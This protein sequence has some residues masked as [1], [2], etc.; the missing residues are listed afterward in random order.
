MDTLTTIINL[1][2]DARGSLF[3]HLLTLLVLQAALV[4]AL[5]HW[6]RGANDPATRRLALAAAGILATRLLMIVLGLFGL[7]GMPAPQAFS[8]TA[9][10]APLERA[11]DTIATLLLLWALLTPRERWGTADLLLGIALGFTLVAAI[12][13]ISSWYPQALAG[14]HYNNSNGDA[15]WAWAQLLLLLAGLVFEVGRVTLRRSG[16]PVQPGADWS[17][18]SLVYALLATGNVLQLLLPTLDPLNPMVIASDLPGPVRVAQVLAWPL[19]AAYVWRHVLSQTRLITSRDRTPATWPAEILS[20]S[21]IIGSSL[22]EHRTIDQIAVAVATALQADVAAVAVPSPDEAGE[23]SLSAVYDR[24]AQ[25]YLS[26]RSFPLDEVTPLRSAIHRRRPLLLEPGHDDRALSRLLEYMSS[27][28]TGLLLIQPMIYGENALGAILVGNP[29]TNRPLTDEDRAIASALAD[30]AALALTLA[31]QHEDVAARAEQLGQIAREREVT[32][33]PLAQQLKDAQAESRHF[34][35]RLTEMQAE[36]DHERENARHLAQVVA[37]DG[38]APAA[39]VR[40]A[41]DLEDAMRAVGERDSEIARLL[42]AIAEQAEKMSALDKELGDV[43]DVARTLA[44]E[45]DDAQAQIA[46]LKDPAEF[47]HLNDQLARTQLELVEARNAIDDLAREQLQL[48]GTQRLPAQ[49]PNTTYQPDTEVLNAVVQ[50]LRTP[51]T[52]LLGYTD[53]LLDESVGILGAMQRKF[54]QRIKTNVERMRGIMDDL[55]RLTAIET[56]QLHLE[57]QPVDL[58]EVIAEAVSR[59]SGQFR[60]KGITLKVALAPGLPAIKADRD[61][62][63]QVFVQLLHNAAL[64]S[65][66]DGEVV[67]EMRREATPGDGPDAQA[68]D[69]SDAGAGGNHIL[70]ALRDSG[71]GIAPEDRPRVFNRIYRAD[72]PLIPGVGDTGVGLSIAKV[73]VEAQGGRIWVDSVTG[74]GSIFNVA[75]PLPGTNGNGPTA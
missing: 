9:V 57:P 37:V 11:A 68:S 15:A 27:A 60:E 63:Y 14:Q 2:G 13:D 1:F 73:L 23:I 29:R 26:A 24:A 40:A 12:F 49:A 32:T 47:Q 43:G 8:P 38:R 28:G 25:A 58:T 64:C 50:E 61:A 66:V 3:Y 67:L 44:H 33:G 46:R 62:L 34:A 74:S 10:A 48:V 7:P 71:G 22:D 20:A 6:R 45:L 16:I 52:S 70:V 51:M 53:L 21:R 65:R 55:I 18:S 36:L 56:G 54:L 35:Q 72:N 41:T 5:D 31:Q 69:N 19:F 59:S 39:P 42:A 30:R 4:I 75:L 17:T